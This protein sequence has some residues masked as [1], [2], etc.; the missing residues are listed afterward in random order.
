MGTRRVRRRPR[1]L[2]HRGRR[3]PRRIPHCQMVK[4][5]LTEKCL[6]RNP[7]ETTKLSSVLSLSIKIRH[8]PCSKKLS[9][10]T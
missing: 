2:R 8:T 7:Y 4:A 1:R 5:S 9:Y 6:C 10:N 3:R